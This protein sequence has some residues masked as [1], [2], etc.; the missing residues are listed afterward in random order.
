MLSTFQ[1]ESSDHL[2]DALAAMKGDASDAIP[3]VVRLL[4]N[5][6]SPLA[7]PGMIDLHRHDCLHLLL[8][9]GF[10]L[11][12]EAFVVGFTMGNDRR[13]NGLHLAIFK[14]CS[15][16]F[17]PRPY[18]FDPSHL[19]SFDAG[20]V[21]GRQARVRNLNQLDFRSWDHQPLQALREWIGIG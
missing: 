20:V 16:L 12:D 19:P 5:P 15:L 8:G 21:L 11:D 3:F 9:R 17:Y 14:A 4:E 1:V 13:T 7:L 18:R 6:A 10:S 2:V